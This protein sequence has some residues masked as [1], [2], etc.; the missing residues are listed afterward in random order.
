M[1]YVVL[2]WFKKRRRCLLICAFTISLFW[3]FFLFYYNFRALSVSKNLQREFHTSKNLHGDTGVG[4][5]E[6]HLYRNK[7]RPN[8]KNDSVKFMHD[9]HNITDRVEESRHADIAQTTAPL[10]TVISR[11]IHI[12]PTK[13]SKNVRQYSGAH[14][15]NATDNL[16]PEWLQLD[17]SIQQSLGG[18]NSS[19]SSLKQKLAGDSWITAQHVLT[20]MKPVSMPLLDSGDKPSGF[21]ELDIRH[22]PDQHKRVVLSVVDSGYVNFAINFQLLSIDPIGLQNFLFVCIDHEAVDILQQ[23][24]IACSY[25]HKSA[26]VQ[27]LVVWLCSMYCIVTN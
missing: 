9:G 7:E 24:G 22:L 17:P 8:V 6:Y 1:F 20:P 4:L 3:I 2:G 18:W 14:E 12:L 27:V 16:I 19:L 26:T 13:V 25:F 5:H 21:F 23:Y 11:A 15:K 10:Y